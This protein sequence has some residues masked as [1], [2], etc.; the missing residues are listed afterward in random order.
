MPVE[1]NP[2]RDM[3]NSFR[4][5]NVPKRRDGLG[6]DD[7]LIIKKLVFILTVEDIPWI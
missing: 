7:A 6:P 1:M 3:V 4:S 2:K 5:D